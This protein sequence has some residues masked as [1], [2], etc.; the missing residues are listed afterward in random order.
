MDMEGQIELYLMTNF[1]VVVILWSISFC[2][3]LSNSWVF[4]LI[5]MVKFKGSTIKLTLLLRSWNIYLYWIWRR[6]K[7]DRY[8]EMSLYVTSF[9]Y[10]SSVELRK[11]L[12][13]ARITS[14]DVRSNTTQGGNRSAVPSV[15]SRQLS[16]V[17]QS[18]NGI[19]RMTLL[20]M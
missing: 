6:W 13:L 17:L 20:I 18:V 1:P 3:Y 9:A 7:K 14:H 4:Q 10:G 15:V 16:P 5:F 12:L 19:A 11:A 2:I 8:N